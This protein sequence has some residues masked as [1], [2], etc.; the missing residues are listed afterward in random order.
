MKKFCEGER[1]YVTFFF[2]KRGVKRTLT[3][4]VST[5]RIPSPIAVSLLARGYISVQKI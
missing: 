2:E 3:I 5:L 1:K 4:M